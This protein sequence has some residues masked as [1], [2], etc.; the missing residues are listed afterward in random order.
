MKIMSGQLADVRK[1]FGAVDSEK[2]E[3]LFEGGSDGKTTFNGS[4]IVKITR[5]GVYRFDDGK[6]VK[7]V[8]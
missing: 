2:C 5:K 1:H 3:I 4:F 6:M 7:R 8:K